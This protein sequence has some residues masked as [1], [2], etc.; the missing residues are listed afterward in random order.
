ME[1]GGG[2]LVKNEKG[3]TLFEVLA[4]IIILTIVSL[5]VFSI[6]STASKQQKEQS[7]EVQQIQDGAYILKEITK[8]IRKSYQLSI[9]TSNNIQQYYLKDKDNKTLFTYEYNSKAELYR[10]GSL[11]G[12]NV[13]N[14]TISGD[15]TV[16][17]NFDLNN[18]NYHTTIVFRRGSAK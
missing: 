8:D 9:A 13:E 17:L 3:M 16:L 10:N 5:F 6:I 7:I 18:K 11:I 12:R 2:V 14:F 4:T 1:I 15:N